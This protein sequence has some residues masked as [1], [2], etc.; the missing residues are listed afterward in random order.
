MVV[1]DKLIEKRRSNVQ[2]IVSA[3]FDAVRFIE[4]NPLEACAIMAEAEG[5]S[6]EEFVHHVEGIRYI[7][8][9]GNKAAFSKE[10][11][12]ELYSTGRD[13]IDFLYQ[14][15]VIKT[16]PDINDLMDGGFVKKLK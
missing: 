1:D 16:Q 11:D 9:D 13:L 6:T 8:L 3:Y 7:N 15:K 10:Q 12:G 14:K 2:K 5:I 4:E